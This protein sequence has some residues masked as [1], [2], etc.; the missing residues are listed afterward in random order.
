MNNQ[1][2][3]EI[4]VDADIML[5]QL[6][7]ENAEELFSLT[8]SNRAYLKQWLPWLDS[9]TIVDDSKNFIIHMCDEYEHK[10]ALQMGIWYKDQLVGSI[11]FHD[12]DHINKKT[13]IGYWLGKSFQG[14]GIII[15]AVKAVLAF[16]FET[17]GMN[18]VQIQ[19][20]TLN[21]KSNA[22]PRKLNFRHEG[23]LREEQWLYDRFVDMNVYSLLKKE[24]RRE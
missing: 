6:Q 19:C 17:E 5:K 24:W 4:Q 10:N 18:K 21:T 11:G 22:I 20:G 12:F 1:N 2:T 9:T 16:A 15:R 7:I 8:D 23:I 13:S 14:K 3:L